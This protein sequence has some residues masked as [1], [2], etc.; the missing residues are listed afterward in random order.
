MVAGEGVSFEYQSTSSVAEGR[1][2]L[3]LRRRLWTWPL[4]AVI[5]GPFVA[6]AAISGIEWIWTRLGLSGSQNSG[7]FG[8]ALAMWGV[9][10]WLCCPVLAIVAAVWRNRRK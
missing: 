6:L 9:G 3:R 10:I 5:Y 2:E 4:L 7:E 8:L 1:L